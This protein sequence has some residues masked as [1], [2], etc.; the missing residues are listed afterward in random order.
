MAVR[1]ALKESGK[2]VNAI[3]CPFMKNLFS[4]GSTEG[5]KR[6]CSWV[7]L[8]SKSTDAKELFINNCPFAK[9]IESIIPPKENEIKDTTFSKSGKSS[10]VDYEKTFSDVISSIKEEGRY[11]EFIPIQRTVGKFPKAEYCNDSKEVTVWCSND[12]L[13]MGQHPNVLQ[14]MTNAITFSGAGSG[15]TRNISGNTK[16][17]I[18]LE[19]ELADL[20][21]KQAALLFSSCYIANSSCISTFGKI[22]PNAILYSDKKNHASLIEGIRNSRLQKKIFNHNDLDHLEE[23]LQQDDINTPKMIIFESVYSMDGS[24]APIKEICELAKKYNALTFIDEV[25]AVGLYGNRGGG[26]AEREGLLDELD[27]V[28]GTLGKAFGVYG[29]Y[30]AASEKFIDV[31]RSTAPGFIFTTSL[32]PVVAAG[33]LESV[34]HLKNSM[35]ERKQHTHQYKLMKKKLRDAGLPILNT[36]SHIIPVI[37]GDAKLCKQASDYLLKEYSIYVQPINYPTVDVGTERFR[38]TPGPLHS[39]KL[40]DEMV[41]ALVKTFN[42][43]NIKKRL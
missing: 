8:I 41:D 29:G 40:M 20:H 21:K 31:M 15:G 39:E 35:V 14:A 5:S 30:I 9:N 1:N 18:Q 7:D 37:I 33:A 25:H 36:Q 34:K 13:G 3:G 38:L 11:R 2:C 17:H 19:S 16:F 4:R 22:M 10:L 32:P 42:Y 27:V 26:V 24:I 23:L 28:S 12:Y 6:T 43:F